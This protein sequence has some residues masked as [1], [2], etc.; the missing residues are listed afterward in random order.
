MTEIRSFSK[1]HSFL[2]NMHIAPI[3]WGGVIWPSTEHAY[4]AAKT[5]NIEQQE[6]IRNNPCP[7]KAKKAGK[8]VDMRP[9][10]DKLKVDVMRSVCFA[11]FTQHPELKQKLID[12]GNA[13]L[14]EGNWWHDNFWGTCPEDS[15]NGQNWLGKILME[16]REQFRVES[17]VE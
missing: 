17:L 6:A 3:R 1:E 14:V 2:S 4:Q 8:K 15:E 13:R 10:W 9:D 12:T 11:K 16:L 5:S 7:K